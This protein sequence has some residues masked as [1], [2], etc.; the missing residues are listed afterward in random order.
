DSYRMS[1]ELGLKANALY[2][3]GCTLSQPLNSKSDTEYERDVEESDD[4]ELAS[5][6]DEIAED[7]AALA[8]AAGDE[9]VRIVIKKEIEI[10]HRPMRRRLA[11]TRR[12]I[13]HK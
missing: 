10:V 8:N 12:S 3:D 5:A 2:R 13:T 1:W 9:K 6:Y 11:D 7:V 4:L